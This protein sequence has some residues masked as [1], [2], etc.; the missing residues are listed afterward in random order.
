[1]VDNS[2]LIETL[3]KAKD[4]HLKAKH[5][6]V[7]WEAVH[8]LKFRAPTYV[9]FPDEVNEAWD[10]DEWVYVRRDGKLSFNEAHIIGM[11][12]VDADTAAVYR[13]LPT[14]EYDPE[15]PDDEDLGHLSFLYWERRF[16]FTA[17]FASEETRQLHKKAREL[18]SNGGYSF[19]SSKG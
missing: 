13:R 1:M 4:P 15:F 5:E 8:Q 6:D 19:I 9:Q 10:E 12:F 7:D 18:Q 16:Y 3:A 2:L 17:A 11:A 14:T